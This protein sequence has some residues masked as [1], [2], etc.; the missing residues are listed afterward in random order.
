MARS[1]ISITLS[2]FCLLGCAEASIRHGAALLDSP[3][4][5]GSGPTAAAARKHNWGCQRI[6]RAITGLVEPMRSARARAEKEEQQIPPTLARLAARVSR[7][8]GA[9]NAALAEF[10]DISRDAVEL[11][12]LFKEKGCAGT[13]VDVE[14]PAFL[15]P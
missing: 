12:S 11:S 5:G 6:E 15:Q 8:P 10:Q 9:G 2:V 4:S 7:R 13:T 14:V 3:L 1:S